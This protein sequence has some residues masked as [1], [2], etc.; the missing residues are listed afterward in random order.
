MRK[1]TSYG[2]G[3]VTFALYAVYLCNSINTTKGESVS[4][5]ID[6]TIDLPLRTLHVLISIPLKGTMSIDK[7]AVE[8]ASYKNF[9]YEKIPSSCQDAILVLSYLCAKSSSSFPRTLLYE[10]IVKPVLFDNRSGG[11]CE[12]FNQIRQ[13]PEWCMKHKMNIPNAFDHVENLN[14]IHGNFA[15]KYYLTLSSDSIGIDYDFKASEVSHPERF[16]Q[17]SYFIT[18]ATKYGV[19]NPLKR[20]TKWSSTASPLIGPQIDKSISE[21]SKYNKFHVTSSLSLSG[22]GMHRTAKHEITVT[23]KTPSNENDDISTSHHHFHSGSVILLFPISKHIF[24]DLDEPSPSEENFGCQIT[25][26]IISEDPSSISKNCYVEMITSKERVMNIEEPSFASSP[27]LLA[28][29]ISFHQK[30][31]NQ[32]ITLPLNLHFFSTL[33]IRYQDPVSKYVNISISPPFVYAGLLRNNE[34][35]TTYKLEY[36]KDSLEPPIRIEVCSGS[37][38]D[39]WLIMFV[40]GIVSVTGAFASMVYF[41]RISSW[42]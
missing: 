25:S 21:D 13:K 36:H 14:T 3:I 38:Q 28:F 4:S 24:L 29:N 18:Q 27:N 17:Q 32:N 15:H 8:D 42:E 5:K 39:V 23:P 22:E 37:Y 34:E 9:S 41:T 40:T 10:T 26:Q 30:Y 1:H 35:T 31:E 7:K 19:F 2:Y 16:L 11:V 20:V 33:H 6:I 12:S